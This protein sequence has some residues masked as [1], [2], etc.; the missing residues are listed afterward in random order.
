MVIV[1]TVMLAVGVAV[2]MVEVA[3]AAV[4]ASVVGCR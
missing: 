2:R 3:M 4:V 1:I